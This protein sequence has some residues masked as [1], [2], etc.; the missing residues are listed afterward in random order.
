MAIAPDKRRKSSSNYDSAVKLVE[1]T[2]LISWGI[3]MNPQCPTDTELTQGAHMWFAIE[4]RRGREHHVA[5]M[6][7]VREHPHFLPLRSADPS[8]RGLPKPIFPGYLF[9]RI[10]LSDR[11]APVVG[12]PGVIRLVGIGRVPTAVP[13]AEIDAIRRITATS[14]PVESE[15]YR[16][17]EKIRVIRGPL[18]GVEGVLLAIKNLHRLIV[19][20]ELIQR[21]VSV[22]IEKDWIAP[23][24]VP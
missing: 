15:S 11:R 20:I 6:L 22:E 7:A 8:R 9:C 1:N 14:V 17:G 18:R 3:C 13:D 4:V 12:I 23:Q 2:N 5:D 21:S 24:D 19:S 16:T 10:N